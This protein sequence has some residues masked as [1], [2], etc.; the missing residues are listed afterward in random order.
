MWGNPE[1]WRMPVTKTV[2]WEHKMYE[3]SRPT[4]LRV[5]PVL[6][7]KAGKVVRGIAGRRQDYRPIVSRLEDSAEPADIA[8]ALHQFGFTETYVADLD[9]IAGAAPEWTSY[10]AI[11]EAGLR[12]WVDAGVCDCPLAERLAQAGVHKIIAGL[13]TVAGPEA[14][15]RICNHLGPEA[16]VFSLDLKDGEPIGNLAQWGSADPASLVGWAVEAGVRS[17]IVLDLARVGTGQGIGTHAVC[18]ELLARWP[19]LEVI[20]GG[21]VRDLADVRSLW[22]L[23]V[24]RVLVASALH[25]G[26]LRPEDLA[27]L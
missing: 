16:V 7:L 11:R 24:Q 27:G 26:R 10:A 19:N 21:G 5:L 12:L 9:A 2:A 23:G 17:V 3:K 13:E 20:A 25:D 22:D 1:A 6:D 18:R 15:A 14:L 4:R 8:R